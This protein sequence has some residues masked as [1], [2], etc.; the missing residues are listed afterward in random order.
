LPHCYRFGQVEIRPA[1]RRILVDGQPAHVGARAFDLLLALIERR[2]RVVSKDE[3]LELVWP[4]LVV[5]ENNLQVQVSALRKLLGPKVLATIP[6]HG[7]RL[8]IELDSD[9]GS[10]PAAAMPT[11]NLPAQLNS[12]VGR[13]REIGE[14]KDLLRNARLVTLTGMGGTGKTRLSLQVATDAMSDYPDGVWFVELAPLADERLVPQ[15]V[16]SVLGVKESAGRPL[17]EALEKHVKDRQLLLILDNCEHLRRACAELAKKLLLSGRGVRILA[18]SREHLHV[19]GETAYPVPSLAVPGRQDAAGG[20]SSGA[21]DLEALTRYEAVRLFVDRAAAALPAFRLRRENAVAVAQVCRHLDGIPLAIELAAARADAL[22]VENIAARLGDRF[23]LLTGGDHTAMPRQQTLR[24]SIDWSYDLLTED[25]RALLQRLAVFAGGWT[26]EAAEAVGVGGGVGKPAVLDL[27]ARLVEKSLVIMDAGGER[28]RLLE[29]VRQYAQERLH[30]SG[31][32]D[33]ARTHHLAF[34][35]A[36]AEKARPE[37]AGPQQGA[38]LAGL[39]LERENLL[40]AHAW[41]DHAHEGAALGLRLAW[42]LKPYWINRGVLD[43]GQRITVE[44]L[45]R[46]GAGERNLARCRG[47]SDA[48]QIGVYMGRYAQAQEYLEESLA[49]AR[50]IGDKRR[51]AGALQPLGL[52]CMGQGN[53]AAAHAHLQEA[54]AMAS[55]LGN[56]REILAALFVLAQ[57]LRVRGELDAAEPLYEQGL[58]LARELQDRESIAIGLLNLA[59]VSIDLE[60]GDRALSMLR[61][62]L[63]IADE[64]G[65]KR[66]GQSVLEVSAGLAALRAEWE[67]AVRLFGAAEAQAAQTGLHRDPADEAFVAPRIARAREALGTAIAAAEAPGGAITYDEAMGAARRWLE[68]IS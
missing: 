33:T 37:L 40:S 31:G 14:I 30:E 1:E 32:E 60:A 47:L 54:L 42:A 46:A 5:E 35:L 44:A 19:T 29:T 25:E 2:D 6:G 28:Y 52:A 16:A 26:L 56:K 8:A 23:S 34:Y 50:E 15:A 11:H 20:A 38:W 27:L 13:E 63:A 18:S 53:M 66:V 62:A 55:E 61:E 45:A 68:D 49:I 43:L 51:I 59:M 64:I 3:L 9:A 17:L 48:G 12:F 58:A 67:W 65:S 57:L 22:S 41:A 7:Y 36:L 39:D 24:A 4:G 21:I 10:S